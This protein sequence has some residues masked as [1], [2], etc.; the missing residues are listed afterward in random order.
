M[1]GAPI[2]RTDAG[3]EDGGEDAAARRTVE[4]VDVP[5][6]AALLLGAVGVGVAVAVS[7]RPVPGAVPVP[8]H[9]GGTVHSEYVTWRR[10]TRCCWRVVY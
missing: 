8:G 5:A 2:V 6:V 1:L 10:G 7:V 3:L 4:E 9:V